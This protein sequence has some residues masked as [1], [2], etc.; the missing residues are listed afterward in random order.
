V[1]VIISILD[2]YLAFIEVVTY[3]RTVEVRNSIEKEIEI[4]KRQA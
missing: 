3:N 2:Y 4:N 1:L